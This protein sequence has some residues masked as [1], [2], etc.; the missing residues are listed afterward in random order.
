MGLK[1][2]TITELLQLIE[3]IEICHMRLMT[4]NLIEEVVQTY[5]D[6][7]YEQ[8]N[9]VI[10]ADVAEQVETKQWAERYMDRLEKKVLRL[11]QQRDEIYK[12]NE[13]EMTRLSR[14]NARLRRRI[15]TLKNKQD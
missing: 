3:S 14:Q 11:E 15:E 13:A 8:L 9:E 1:R 2:E 6:G 4:D 10:K 12:A 5:I 7:Y